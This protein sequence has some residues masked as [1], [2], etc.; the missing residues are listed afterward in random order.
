MPYQNFNEEFFSYA[1]FS[2]LQHCPYPAWICCTEGNYLWINDSFLEFFKVEKEQVIGK[3]NGDF[4]PSEIST[5]SSKNEPKVQSSHIPLTFNFK[6]KDFHTKIFKNPILNNSNEIIGIASMMTDITMKQPLEE[7]LHHNKDFYSYILGNM[8]EALL[9]INTKGEFEFINKKGEEFLDKLGFHGPMN[10]QSWHDF[11]LRNYDKDTGKIYT[12][13]NAIMLR[14]LNGEEILNHE[15]TMITKNKDKITFR[16]SAIPFRDKNNNSILGV[17]MTVNDITNEMDMLERL[18]DKKRLIEQR[19]EE[20]H[21]FAYSAAH[22]LRDPLRNISLSTLLIQENLQ[23]KNY[24]EVDELL[25]RLLNTTN[26]GSSLV[27]NLL[28]YSA[29]NQEMPMESICLEDI[30]HDNINHLSSLLAQAGAEITYKQ[31]PKV[32]GNRQQ[33]QILFQNIISNAIRY[34]GGS[35]LKI[36]ISATKNNSFWE[37]SIQDNGPGIDQKFKDII[38]LPFKRLSVQQGIRSTGLGLSICRR[39]VEQ[40]DGKIW[41]ED[42]PKQ[43]A[44]FKFT[45]KS[46][47]ENKLT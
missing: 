7:K 38:F 43:G 34:R 1:C 31:L 32:L 9:F 4:L 42:S 22:D 47:E 13:D 18:E 10:F 30:V 6:G 11:F 41:Y 29:A 36:S 21:Q 27:K 3:L 12:K 16:A 20:L 44:C 24:E 40:H 33:L 17:I 26:Y 45:L 5:Q 25:K 15:V 28:D 46:L 39:I 35:P 14:S 8:G 23:K 2:L 37:I 19:N